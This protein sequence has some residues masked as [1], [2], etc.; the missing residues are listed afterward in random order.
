M[1]KMRRRAENNLFTDVCG[2]F[3]FY[4]SDTREWCQT[5]QSW[6]S[7]TLISNPSN[8]I[9]NWVQNSES[10]KSANWWANITRVQCKLTDIQDF[11]WII[12]IIL[13]KKT[14]FFWLVLILL[15]KQMNLFGKNV[16]LFHH[17][18]RIFEVFLKNNISTT[19]YNTR[20]TV[21][22]FAVV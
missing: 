10:E 1:K 3:F 22:F 7:W 11:V 14:A 17:T 6:Q 13:V 18:G 15:L 16:E 5:W 8:L 21:L 12:F 9:K 20:Y 4:F 19:K 2:F